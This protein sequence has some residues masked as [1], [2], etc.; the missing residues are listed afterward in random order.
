KNGHTLRDSLYLK[1]GHG[2]SAAEIEAMKQAR[3]DAWYA[4]VTTPVEN[5]NPETPT[6]E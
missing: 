4:I 1:I 5:P 6:E 2:H 3:F